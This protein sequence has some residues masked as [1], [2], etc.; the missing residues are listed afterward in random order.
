MT[1]ETKMGL[2]LGLGMILFLGILVSDFLA[3]DTPP[4]SVQMT[5]FAESAQQSL[6][7]GPGELADPLYDETAGDSQADRASGGLS[8]RTTPLPT[9]QE[10][11]AAPTWTPVA[12]DAGQRRAPKA[13]EAL[14][15]ARVA[16][17]NV[18]NTTAQRESQPVP[19]LTLDGRAATQQR[20]E[21]AANTRTA[22]TTM[23]HYVQ[24]NET[25]YEIAEQYYGD[26]AYWRALAEANAGK[27]MAGG[28]VRPNVRLTI[29]NLAGLATVQPQAK[30]ASATRGASGDHGV[31]EV[32]EGDTLIGLARDFLGDED[33]WRDLLEYN[34]DQLTRPEQ[35]RSGMK[36]KLP[37]PSIARQGSRPAVPQTYTVQPGDTLSSIARR[38][39]GDSERWDEL[40]KANRN[41]LNNPNALRV[42][43]ELTIPG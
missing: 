9:P 36:L 27:T 16:T 19:S 29:P 5:R 6:G 1:R 10:L 7:S 15:V 14:A 4:Q 33:R 39:M 3:V 30:Q 41:L 38:Q 37:L 11:E 17:N 8:E 24:P 2:L 13:I 32:E 42:G 18:T 22:P 23:I 35:L 26:G 20:D 28:H 31:V 40:Y 12:P 25:L 43:Q 21:K 34:S